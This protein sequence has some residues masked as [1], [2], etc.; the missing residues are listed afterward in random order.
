MVRFNKNF[1]DT[2][3]IYSQDNHLTKQVFGD[4]IQAIKEA[5]K[6]F[7]LNQHQ[8]IVVDVNKQEAIR[9]I[10]FLGFRCPDLYEEAINANFLIPDQ[11][12]KLDI[13]MRL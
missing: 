5:Q 1:G 13:S 12:K 6:T 4:S 2:F 8:S 9:Q 7:D 10:P 11:F 3:I